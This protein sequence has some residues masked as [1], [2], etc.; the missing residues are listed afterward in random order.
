MLAGPGD[1]IPVL[2]APTTPTNPA[3]LDA[4]GFNAAQ[5]L[6]TNVQ[7]LVALGGGITLFFTKNWSA[8]LG[9]AADL[10]SGGKVANRATLSVPPGF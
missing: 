10:R 6:A 9:Y 3:A 1:L 2:T 8:S 5:A 4:A 7:A